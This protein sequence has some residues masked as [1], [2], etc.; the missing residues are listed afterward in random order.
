MI[1]FRH[2]KRLLVGSIRA[3]SHSSLTPHNDGD[4]KSS[5]PKGRICM[6][7]ADILHQ[8]S[9]QEEEEHWSLLGPV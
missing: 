9:L 8:H 4:F 5:I 7:I 2:L 1:A 3:T 6:Y